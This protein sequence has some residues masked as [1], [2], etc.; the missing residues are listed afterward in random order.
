M[1]LPI[2]EP[3]YTKASDGSFY[4]STVSSENFNVADVKEKIVKLQEAIDFLKGH[5]QKASEI[6]VQ[7]ATDVL[8]EL[9]NVK[10]V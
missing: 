5:L 10:P 9:T 2:F 3:T 8:T 4:L 7:D 6:G 1:D